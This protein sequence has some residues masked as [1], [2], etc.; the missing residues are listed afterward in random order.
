MTYKGSLLATYKLVNYILD[1]QNQFS[2]PNRK[3]EPTWYRNFYGRDGFFENNTP[4]PEAPHRLQ[5]YAQEKEDVFINLVQMNGPQSTQIIAQV[6]LKN[7]ALSPEMLKQKAVQI[8]VNNPNAE[9]PM[10]LQLYFD[11]FHS[12]DRNL[13]Y[14]TGIKPVGKLTIQDARLQ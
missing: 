7:P 5:I 14:K 8:A 2:F 9:A 1:P 10:L 13:I 12:H 3:Q 11:P 4:H 6:N